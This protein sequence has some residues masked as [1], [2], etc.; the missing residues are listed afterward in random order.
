M[1]PSGGKYRD[2]WAKVG[3]YSSLGFLLPAA[4]LAGFG[5]GWLVDRWLGTEP[6]FGILVGMLGA[7]A[8]FVELLRL[9]KRSEGNTNRNGNPQNRH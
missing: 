8:G 1:K 2:L 6:V 3:F 7:G 5:L 4:A 9:L